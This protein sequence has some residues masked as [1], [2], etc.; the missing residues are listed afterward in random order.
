MKK[1]LAILITAVIL[2]AFP[3]CTNNE[4]TDTDTAPSSKP[5]GTV[6][7]PEEEYD[8]KDVYL[9]DDLNVNYRIRFPKGTKFKT[10]NTGVTSISFDD[11]IPLIDD[12]DE[13]YSELFGVDVSKIKELKDITPAF[14]KSFSAMVEC[15]VNVVNTYGD[16]YLEIISQTDEKINGKDACKTE[17]YYCYHK[18]GDSKDSP[19]T[20]LYFVAYAE[21]LSDGTPMHCA[22]VD[23]TE[24]QS[25]NDYVKDEALSM[26]SSM[27][28]YN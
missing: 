22:V 24:D 1:I 20:K 26:I 9:T 16:P 5:T 2:I 14:E 25:K 19:E 12:L 13:K 21:F 7:V 3:S 15:S 28:E 27:E 18:F 4:N 17:G 11:I 8:W 23:Q 10:K 6:S